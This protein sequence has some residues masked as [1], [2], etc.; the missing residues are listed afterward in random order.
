MKRRITLFGFLLTSH[1]SAQP[2]PWGH[3]ELSWWTITTPHFQIHYHMSDSSEYVLSAGPRRTAQRVAK[4][5]EEVY[6]PLAELY[7]YRPGLIHIIIRDTDDYSNG[8]AY[9]YDNKLE[10]WATNLDYDLRGNHH[11]LYNV[12]THELAHMFSIQTMMKLPKRVPAFYLQAIGYEKERRK[13]VLRGFP[14]VV[15]SYPLSGVTVPVWF[16]EGVAQYQSVRLGHEFWDSHRDMI[17]RQR[18]LTGT[19]LS[20]GE[21]NTFGKNSIGNESAYNSGYAFVTYLCSR[22]GEDVIAR[23][24]SE[25][26]KLFKSFESAVQSATGFPLQTLYSDWTKHIRQFYTG[27]EK[28]ASSSRQEGRPLFN[29]GTANFLPAFSPNG[30]RI[31]FISNRGR[32]YLSQTRLF[33][34]ERAS[35]RLT[36][37]DEGVNGPMAWTPDGRRI[38]YSRIGDDNAHHAS[39]SDLYVYDIENDRSIRLTRG[40]RLSAPAIS[41]IDSSVAAVMNGDG[42]QNLVLVRGIDPL[43][44][45]ASISSDRN[46]PDSAR[47]IFLTHHIDGTQIYR[48]VFHP[49]GKRIFFDWSRDRERAIRLL[50]LN[51]LQFSDAIDS[52]G[53]DRSPAISPDG[54]FLV[55][56]SDRTG[57]FNLYRKDLQSG[58]E[59]PLTHTMGGCF[60]PSASPDGAVIFSIYQANA[61]SLNILDSLQPL[62]IDDLAYD[63]S[64]PNL[65][66]G[67]NYPSRW[68]DR[69]IG[70][71]DLNDLPS[72][73][74]KTVFQSFSILPIVRLDYGVI[75]PGFYVYS[76]DFLNKSSFFGGLMIGGPDLDR[77]A[78]AVF[79]YSGHGPVLFLELYNIRRSQSFKDNADPTNDA[80]VVNESIQKNTFELREI[81]V[82]I[83]L[84]LTTPRDLRIVF[85]HPEYFVKISGKEFRSGRYESIPSTGAIKYFFGND[86]WASWTLNTLL[87]AVDGDINPRGGRR[88]NLRYGYYADNLIQGFAFNSETG[89]T[90]ELYEKTPHFRLEHIWSEFIPSPISHHSIEFQVQASFIPSRVDSFYHFFG[91]G[92][93]GL[94]GYSFY[95]IEGRR[96][97]LTML[98]YRFPIWRRIDKNLGFLYFEKVFG[99][100]YA[101]WGNAWSDK[102]TWNTLHDFKKDIGVELRAEIHSFYVYPTRVALRAAYGLDKF[103]TFGPL[104]TQVDGGGNLIKVP[105]P[106][107][108][109]KE[110]RFYATVLF[111]F[112]LFDGK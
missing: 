76:A 83:D 96:M 109:G 92:L 71:L 73:P 98:H 34:M 77:D 3:P 2:E 68:V 8:S 59:E 74:Y 35:G 6:E 15:T 106:V 100:L 56:S 11:W 19:L 4:I 44:V 42:T 54:R 5:A 16:A 111:G 91:G 20:L 97:L 57:I 9:Y 53:D 69:T 82:G 40:M 110:W 38:L 27:Q 28:S 61:Y 102:T 90:E 86:V 58:L 78:F 31:A 17:L 29:E 99:A 63:V 26:R 23:I 46:I 107:R 72:K 52:R 47:I 103:T 25:N 10:I 41:P 49:D 112:S 87:P 7:Q 62:T 94:K 21:M 1:V 65:L 70:E 75:K 48:P 24:C 18:A 39:V 66:T 55:Y 37:I 14:N 30:E 51:T 84:G 33:V 95:S 85:A 79:E 43:T 101:G 105:Q 45:D 93:P 88:I 67:T 32:D 80:I 36:E 50:D 13:D 64:N 108:N 22:F 81:D 89:S 60:Y 104:V 12:V